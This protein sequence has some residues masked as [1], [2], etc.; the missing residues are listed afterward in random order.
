MVLGFGRRCR[1]RGLRGDLPSGTRS[2]QLKEELV[3]EKWNRSES[4]GPVANMCSRLKHPDLILRVN[5]GHIPVR[6]R[7]TILTGNFRVR[8]HLTCVIA[9]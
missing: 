2:D 1:Y 6:E 4:F 3:A 5:Q 9:M 8:L 7:L